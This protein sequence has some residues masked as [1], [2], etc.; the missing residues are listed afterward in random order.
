MPVYMIRAGDT[1]MVKIGWSVV[2]DRC[3]VLQT[4]HYERLHVIRVIDRGSRK[5]EKWLHTRFTER[6]VLNEWFRFHQDMMEIIPPEYTLFQ[7]PQ[8]TRRGRVVHPIYHLP[9][10]PPALTTSDLLDRIGG[11][12]P[13]SKVLLVTPCAVT[14]WKK[15]GIPP[16]H[17]LRIVNHAKANKIDGVTFEAIHAARKLAKPRE[18]AE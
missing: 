9:K 2:G 6:R 1:E 3:A 13:A 5:A 18:A 16:M 7:E 8:P 10:E 14:L 4:A 15:S 12:V 11:I 17:W